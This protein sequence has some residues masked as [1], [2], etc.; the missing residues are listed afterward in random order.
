[1]D[2]DQGPGTFR[3]QPESR[4]PPASVRRRLSSPNRVNSGPIFNIQGCATV[5]IGDANVV[6]GDQTVEAT[7][8]NR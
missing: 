5:Q 8:N 6:K 4:R 1:M 3:H 7:N 2:V